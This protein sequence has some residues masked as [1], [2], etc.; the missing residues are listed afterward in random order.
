MTEPDVQRDGAPDLPP[1]AAPRSASASALRER[2]ELLVATWSPARLAASALVV[3]GIVVAAVVLLRPAGAAPPP[4]ELRLPMASSAS[5]PPSAAGPTGSSASAGAVIVVH[6]AG[7]VVRPGVY[8]LPVGSRV[9]DAVEAAGGLAPDADGDR[10]NLAAPLSDGQRV[11]VP[12]VGQPLP[13]DGAGSSSSG[14]VDLN[15]ATEADLDALPGIGPTTAKAI[16]DE[17]SRRGGRFSSV[18]DLLQVRG[19]GPA[20]LDQL[21]PLVTVG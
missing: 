12:K 17:R 10:I 16:V 5:G 8:R 9:E 15:T 7:A 4:P 14:P 3:I 6:A 13:D 18:D 11:F 1:T 20:K 19:I 2:A 21:R